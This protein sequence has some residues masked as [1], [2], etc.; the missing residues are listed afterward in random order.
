[1]IN[2]IGHIKVDCLDCPQM[3]NFPKEDLVWLR[4]HGFNL[5]MWCAYCSKTIIDLSL[6]E[7]QW[8]KERHI[9]VHGICKS[10]GDVF[11]IAP[12][13]AVWL[14]EHDLKLFKRCPVCRQKNKEQRENQQI[15][16]DLESGVIEDEEVVRTESPIAD[17]DFEM[18]E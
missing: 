17:V 16:L 15:A 8:L 1:M 14:L 13:E 10:C 18:A 12:E 9:S 7:A 5:N 2:S 6:E 4:G 3:K 11:F